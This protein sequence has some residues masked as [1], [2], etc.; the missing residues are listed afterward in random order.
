MSWLPRCRYRRC[1]SKNRQEQR[2]SLA[3][4]LQG[5]KSNRKTQQCFTPNS[6][7]VLITQAAA[8][9][10]SSD[11]LVARI[12]STDEVESVRSHFSVEHDFRLD[13]KMKK[14]MESIGTTAKL[15]VPRINFTFLRSSEVS[16]QI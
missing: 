1:S 14:V 3:P 4:H 16:N 13:R 5:P 9:D 15:L 7:R 10:L 8:D 11:E 2:M 12:L 6:F